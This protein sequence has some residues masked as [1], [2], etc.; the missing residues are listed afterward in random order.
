[1]KALAARWLPGMVHEDR[2]GDAALMGT[3]SAMVERFTPEQHADQI[4]R[5]RRAARRGRPTARHRPAPSS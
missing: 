5:P 4:A 1:M 2:H 3:L